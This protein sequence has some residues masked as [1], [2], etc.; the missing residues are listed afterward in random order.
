MASGSA[1]DLAVDNRE[2]AGLNADAFCLMALVTSDQHSGRQASLLAAGVHD[3]Q[4]AHR[5]TGT[6][7]QSPA[8]AKTRIATVGHHI[9]QPAGLERAGSIAL[10]DQTRRIDNSQVQGTAINPYFDG[11]VS[12][13]NRIMAQLENCRLKAFRAATE[14]LKFHRAAAQLF[15]TQPAVTLQIKE[16][17]SD[18]GVRVF[19][20]RGGKVSLTRQGSILLTCAR[21]VAA[22]VSE[23]SNSSVSRPLERRPRVGKVI[24]EREGRGDVP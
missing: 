7:G 5:P 23:G 10:A 4:R 8:S 18:L 9:G 12:V 21:E 16:L 17:Q 11:S 22:M 20:R 1:E 19:D 2:S 6:R 24:D 14:H 13:H 15:L 3:G